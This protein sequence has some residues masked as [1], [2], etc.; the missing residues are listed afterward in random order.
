MLNIGQNDHTPYVFISYTKAQFEA[1]DDQATSAN[2][3][4]LFK[5]AI[6]A[7]HFYADSLGDN[8]RKPRAFWID[9]ECQPLRRFNEVTRTE[10]NVTGEMD[11]KKLVD[12]DVSFLFD[13][14]V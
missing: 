6:H 14:R 2:Y 8:P 9:T 12:H 13:S 5:G 1:G 11:I 3:Q 10:Y 7:T 4:W